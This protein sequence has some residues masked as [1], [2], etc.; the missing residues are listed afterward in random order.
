[1]SQARRL[2]GPKKYLAVVL[3]IL[4]IL[5]IWQAAAGVCRHS[6]CRVSRPWSSA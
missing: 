2:T 3:A 1:M 4:F 5:L 6:S